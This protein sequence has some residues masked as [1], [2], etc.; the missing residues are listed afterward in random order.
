VNGHRLAEISARRERLVARAG[1]QRDEVALLLAPWRGPLRIADQG[2]VAADYVRAHPGIVVVA[3]AAFVILSPKRAFRW[4]RRAYVAWR[5]YRWAVRALNDV[6]RR[7]R[8]PS[9]VRDLYSS[10]S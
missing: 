10:Q 4:A 6:A 2:L 5:G 7:G 8:A 9:A 3:A 1:A